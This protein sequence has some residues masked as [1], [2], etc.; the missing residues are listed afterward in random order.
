[1]KILLI[2][3]LCISCLYAKA[4]TT[5]ATDVFKQMP[6][7]MLPYLTE[8]NKLDMID[9]VNA[10][11]KSEVTNRFGGN[12]QMLKLDSTYLKIQL[13]PA[14]MLELKL[15]KPSAQLKD[16]AEWVVCMLTTYGVKSRE[17]KV[18]FYSSKWNTLDIASPITGLD[19]KQFLSRP[20]T[21]SIEKYNE[22]INNPEEYIYSASLSSTDES[23]TINASTTI[24][25]KEQNDILKPL[26]VTKRLQWDGKTF[27]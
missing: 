24:L 11:M 27:K 5:T 7:N 9:F 14:V 8:N 26:F 2:A 21:M 12:T 15:L 25:M 13:N 17:S 10:N 4:Q 1:M 6:E 3:F 20:D 16:S 19:F 22:I 18:E 23:M